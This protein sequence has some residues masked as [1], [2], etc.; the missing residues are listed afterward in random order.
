[1]RPVLVLVLAIALGACQRESPRAD[2][3]EVDLEA[4]AP[5]GC[6][7]AEDFDEPKTGNF[8]L[9]DA[10]PSRELSLTRTSEGTIAID[11]QRTGA[12][13]GWN[14]V[15]Y[16]LRDGRY[17]IWTSESSSQQL[18]LWDPGRQFLTNLGRGWPMTTELGVFIAGC[19][20][21]GSAL[22]DIDPANAAVRVVWNAY[23]RAELLGL[24]RGAPLFLRWRDSAVRD[25]KTAELTIL[26]G[27]GRA[28]TRTVDI[29]RELESYLLH[30]SRLLLVRRFG[31]ATG[32][33]SGFDFTWDFPVYI[34]DV[35]S[36]SLRKIGAARSCRNLSHRVTVSGRYPP[37]LFWG[38]APEH[39]DLDDAERLQCLNFVDPT[40]EEVVRRIVTRYREPVR[41]IDCRIWDH[42]RPGRDA[43]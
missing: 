43:P 33:G 32:P 19:G 22:C 2:S 12:S 42:H 9:P 31:D 23:R 34:L 21:E 16:R 13:W 24:Y 37:T 36:L 26:S 3:N 11:G 28:Q 38:H 10:T 39:E 5:E 17:L 15:V 40:T 30:D 14:R 20:E 27:P 8:N 6:F 7:G 1:M 4:A 25:M 18:W 29:A 41:A 35:H